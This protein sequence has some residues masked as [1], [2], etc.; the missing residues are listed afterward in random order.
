MSKNVYTK[1]KE[2]T[3]KFGVETSDNCMKSITFEKNSLSLKTSV[4][5]RIVVRFEVV[6]LSLEGEVCIS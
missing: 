4:G 2:G 6:L 5:L 1:T 3:G